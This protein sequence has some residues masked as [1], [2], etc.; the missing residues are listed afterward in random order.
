MVYSRCRYS[1]TRR[2]LLDVGFDTYLTTLELKRCFGVR[3]SAFRYWPDLC[4][5]QPVDWVADDAC[6]QSM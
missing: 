6:P 3:K 5:E 2:P 1:N 4:N